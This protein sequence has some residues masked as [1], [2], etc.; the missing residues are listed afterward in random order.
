MSGT[1]SKKMGIKAGT[2]AIFV[3]APEAAR[4]AINPPSLNVAS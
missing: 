3:N 4:G 1:V 2:R